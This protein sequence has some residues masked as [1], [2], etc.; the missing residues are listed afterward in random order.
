[1][2][3]GMLMKF[4]LQKKASQ[5]CIQYNSNLVKSD[6]KKNKICIYDLLVCKIEEN[7]VEG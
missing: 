7:A 6:Q 1:M 2:T 5:G 3:S 4:R